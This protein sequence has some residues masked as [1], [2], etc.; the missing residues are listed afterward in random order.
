MPLSQIALLII[1]NILIY[2]RTL[3]Y[4]LVIDDIEWYG[5][6]KRGHLKKLPLHRLYG[7]ASISTNTTIDHATTLSLHIIT[8]VL[9]AFVSNP[10]AALLFAAHPANHQTAVWLTGRR[11]AL[12]NIL[13]LTTMLTHTMWLLP[14]AAIPILIFARKSYAGRTHLPYPSI[15]PIAI[16]RTLGLSLWKLFGFHKP[17]FIYPHKNA[18]SIAPYSQPVAE[19]HLSIPLIAICMLI[20][21]S[22]L[23]YALICLY[24]LK[25]HDL[26]PMYENIQAFYD[27]H[28][29][30]G[31]AHSKQVLLKRLYHSI[32]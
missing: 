16:A 31:L 24:A 11:Y 26:I 5:H 28:V 22:P 23:S 29:V 6:V 13:V 12:I 30:R 14:I 7:A 1:F 4:G 8:C 32:V 9:I 19:R 10:V 18:L 25:T 20:S 2:Y 27:Y 3:S 15:T 17:M 21:N